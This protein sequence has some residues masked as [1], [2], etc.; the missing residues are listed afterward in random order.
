VV[1]GAGVLSLV[2]F[3]RDTLQNKMEGRKKIKIKVGSAKD[4]WQNSA[5]VGFGCQRFCVRYE[6]H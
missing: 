6:F 4:L 3:E 5:K 1:C 2:E